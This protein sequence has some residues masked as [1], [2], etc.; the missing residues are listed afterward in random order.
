M[1]AALLFP[2]GTDPRSPHLAIPSLAA[3][4]RRAGA[5]VTVRD[6][7]LEGLLELATPARVTLAAR[8]CRRRLEAPSAAPDADR[9]RA[10]LRWADDLRESLPGAVDEL[11]DP[12]GF[13]DPHRHHVARERLVNALELVSAAAG[14]VR[15]NIGPIRYDVD[16]FDPS[17]LRDLLALT[18][19]PQHN[20]FDSLYRESL[21]PALARDRPDVVG[22]SILNAQQLIPGLYLARALK[23][24]GHFVVIGGTVF[25][26]FTAALARR[27]AFFR[28]FCDGLIAYEGETA[29]AELLDRRARG[30][31]LDGV[32]NLLYL[33][34]RGRVAAG[35]THAEDVN[36][37][38]TPDFDGL[39]LDRYLAPAPVLPIL[40]GKGCYFN[41]CKFCDIPSI[42]QIAGKAYRVRDPAR[43]AEDVATLHLRHGARHFEI[44]DEALAPKLLLRLA[45]ALEPLQ[46]I[47][48]RFV[49]YARL[50]P[51]F[52][53]AV[54]R[55]LH[56]MGV[57]KLFFGL[58][59]GSQ[60]VLD[61]MD[62]GVRVDDARAVLRRCAAAGIAVHLFSIVGFPEE[63]P[64]DVGETLRFFLDD[65]ALL[66]AP[67]NSFDIHPFTLDLR[68]DY[69]RAA[70]AGRMGIHVEP[71]AL[72]GRDFPLGIERWRNTHGIAPEEVPGVLAEVHAAL[73][74]A[75]PNYRNFPAH[76]WP[77][78]EEYSLL[79][80]DH[81]E[82]RAFPYRLN[83]PPP[84]DRGRFALT[85]SAQLQVER[86]G[87]AVRL[88]SLLGDAITPR[89]TV[90]A[91][92]ELPAQRV[93]CVDALLDA[94]A[95]RLPVAAE[96]RPRV[97]AALREPIDILLRVGVLRLI[98]EPSEPSCLSASTP[99][100]A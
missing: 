30:R 41:R 78:F 39:P 51:G 47:R 79:Y 95:A 56:A 21:L 74:E 26:K 84:G 28:A 94:L 92:A 99:A 42:N 45:D 49:G 81:Y 62:K 58:E 15:Y 27:P 6:L 83:L 16:G 31:S 60:A 82:G 69:A 71:G 85:W 96:Q 93:G 100:S 64:A 55:R 90:A 59:S 67:H 73:R 23:R 52:T 61:H 5:R 37:L 7:D 68:T 54:C 53:A 86:A 65:A 44:T 70:L 40:T 17:R 88:R 91:L 18:D 12:V 63:T 11:R 35:P 25:S 10:A 87:D 75:F 77:G 76:L 29:L 13:F 32:P 57:R 46:A 14:R 33:D 22:V 9:L 89:A 19:A 24:G 20:L 1:H 80:C 72:A 48:P 97:A 50:E 2:P 66:D 98:P 8:D 38:P 3:Y 34:E 36:A 43:V 4:L